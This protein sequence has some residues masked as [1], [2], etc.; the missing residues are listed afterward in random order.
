MIGQTISHFQ[1]VK[2]LG[3][4][5]MGV[6]YLAD[7]LVL[8]RKAAVKILSADYS[9]NPDFRA[10]FRR[11]AQTGAALNHPNIVTIYEV[12]E[13]EQGAFIAMEY[14]D[15]ESLAVLIAREQLYF[16]KALEIT[17]QICQGLQK[18]HQAGIIH[19]DIKPGNIMIDR[20]GQVKILDFGLAKLLGD[21]GLTQKSMIMGTPHYMSPEQ[22]KGETLDYR[23]DIFSLGVVLYELLTQKLPFQGDSGPAVSYA[24]VHKN[25]QPISDYTSE[26]SP[27]LEKIVE[28]ALQKDPGLRYRRI[29]EMLSDL[30][31]ESGMHTAPAETELL[32]EKTRAT[33]IIKPEPATKEKPSIR[34][35]SVLMISSALILVVAIL[36]ILLFPQLRGL[37]QAQDS[38]SIG[39]ISILTIPEGAEVF[40]GGN[41]IGTTPLSNRSIE[42]GLLSL[43][44][45]KSDFFS[46]DTSLVIEKN[47]VASFSFRMQSIARVSIR[48]IPTNADVILDDKRIRLSRLAGLALA[49]GEHQITITAAGFESENH[50]FNLLQGDNPPI[51]YEL[52]KII[53]SPLF[54]TLRV[55]SE[56][57][58]A[59]VFLNDE[60]KGKTAFENKTLEPGTY[61]VLIRL[62][63]YADYIKTHSVQVGVVTNVSV[64]LVELTGVMSITSQPTN[65]AVF[66]DNRG[67]GS[68]PIENL[69]VKIGDHKIL[70]Q[71]DGY[72]DYSTLVKVESNKISIVDRQLIVLTGELRVLVQPYGTI[73]IDDSVH[74][75]DADYSYN[76]T[77]SAGN[78]LVKVENQTFGFWEKTVEI[79][80]NEVADIKI[81]FRNR[82]K[83][84]VTALGVPF[85]DIYVDNQ[86]TGETTPKEILVGVGNRKIE[87]RREGYV[88]EGGVKIINIDKDR[89]EPL[90][91]R[92]KKVQ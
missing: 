87:V 36:S 43:R 51:T 50:R 84:S 90:V 69:K 32:I 48:V 62:S 29:D 54:G 58:N 88:I 30:D 53:K 4:G 11:E 91:F 57:T 33:E 14:V 47:Q 86:F 75:K 20:E 80:P 23:T 81:D 83:I 77:I 45:E 89:T 40:E 17:I 68:T 49:A 60:L 82:V 56:P 19:R 74:I 22:T 59:S 72:E 27:G 41:S 79:R 10:R 21:T 25:A 8:G 18:A 3:Q 76:F 24:I 46:I 67:I 42:A 52:E 61:R 38:A 13:F 55:T 26:T 5:G 63:G 85:A 44:L 92:L 16:K 78:H 70:I 2:K 7:D 35:K 64:R 12:G 73:T 71:K 1:I 65:A 28:K 9:D 39:T 31:S 37:F 6:V 15:G 66:V 34:R